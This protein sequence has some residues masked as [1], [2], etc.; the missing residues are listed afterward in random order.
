MDR[1]RR[2]IVGGHPLL[3]V[4]S[5]EESR[6]E[7]LAQHLAKTFFG[8]PVPLGIWS[9]VDGL[10]VDGVPVPETRDPVKALEAILHAQGRG[11]YVMKDFPAVGGR[12]EI[13]RRLRDLYRGL[14]ERGRHVLLVSPRLLLPE[15]AKKEIFVVEYELPDESEI[16]RILE[17]HMKKR[18]GQ[19]DDTA[20]KRMA[21]ALRGLTADEIGH[22]VAKVF[23]Q[24]T[25][26][27]EEAFQEILAEKEQ[28]S[29]K[30][31]VLEFVPPRF[32]IED[33]G[34]YDTLKNW[35]KKRQALFSKEALDAGIPIPKG[36][37]L[38]GISG[39]GKSLAVK[40]ISTLWNLPLFRLDMN[41]VFGTENPEATFLRALRSV[42]AVS[43]AVLWIDE[44]EMGVGGYKEGGD[45]SMSRIFSGFLTW[46]QEKSALVFVAATANRIHLLPAE[47]IRKGRFDQVFFVDLPNEEERKQIFHIHLKRNRCDPARFDLVF[48]SKATKGWNGAEIEQAVVSA[49]VDSYSEKRTVTEEDLHRVIA[50]TVPLAVTMEEQIKAIKSWAH[51][52][53]LNAS[54]N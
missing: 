31:G 3:Y 26:L 28:M 14:K 11:F 49:A 10:V 53:A 15:E 9:L 36:L 30:E 37:L 33:I 25:A 22:V 16:L 5:W 39:C 12:P 52:R 47:I 23:A 46:M 38:M 17:G 40:T 1:I 32:S 42:E 35:L 45:A 54:K 51:D 41:A 21:L 48:L 2:A 50:A 43:P 19:L 34:G 29:K 8:T 4:Q 7:R 20:S 18:G 27:D 6:V 13:T 44:I 24:R